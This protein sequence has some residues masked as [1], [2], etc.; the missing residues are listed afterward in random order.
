TL[1]PV[2]YEDLHPSC[3]KPRERVEAMDVAG[4]L[5]Q[6]IFPQYPRFC[7]QLFHEARDKDLALL[8]VQAWND[9]MIDEWCAAAPG[10]FISMA[11][12]PLWDGPLAAKEAERAISKGARAIIFSENVAELGLPSIHDKDG[13]WNPLMALANE[14]GLPICMH[15][16]S[17]SKL[18]YLAPD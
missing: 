11:R 16:G 18:P 7:G 3:W 8:C 13:F 9:F 1:A 10:R 2:N 4:I 6:T 12:V 17:S 15:V 14:T 5:A